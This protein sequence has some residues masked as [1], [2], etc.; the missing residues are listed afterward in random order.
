VLAL[1]VAMSLATGVS[2]AAGRSRE[3]AVDAAF[4]TVN[5]VISVA[6][7]RWALVDAV[8]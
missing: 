4:F 7:F 3:I 1:V 6:F 8:A 2:L 5:G